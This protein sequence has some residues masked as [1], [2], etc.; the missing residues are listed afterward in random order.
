MESSVLDSWNPGRQSFLPDTK[1]E[2]R[3]T[4]LLTGFQIG[5]R[6][7]ALIDGILESSGLTLSHRRIPVGCC[8]GVWSA[9]TI[10]PISA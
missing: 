9:L 2:F 5:I 7:G 6:Q 3:W 1:L 8:F 10:G 4:L